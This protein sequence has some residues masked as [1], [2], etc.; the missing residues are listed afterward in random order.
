MK[1][2]ILI[3]A[4]LFV[5]SGSVNAGQ[6]KTKAQQVLQRYLD[7]PATQ[8][9]RYGDE[10]EKRLAILGE[11]KQTPEESVD[12][13]S[14]LLPTIEKSEQRAELAEY[15]GKNFQT[16][17]S[18]DI[19]CK[20]LKDTD[21]EVR[22][23][24]IGAIRLLSRRIDRT[25]A[26]RIQRISDNRSGAD[27]ER[28]IRDT[29]QPGA[30]V[31][32]VLTILPQDESLNEFAEFEP[33]VTGLVPYLV[34]AANDSVE[35]NKIAAMYALADSREPAAVTELHKLLRDPNENI[36][37]YAACFLT[38]FQDASGLFVMKAALKRLSES[39][40]KDLEFEYYAKSE[41]L[42]SSFERITGK[43]MGEIPMNPS[44]SS[45]TRQFEPLKKAHKDLLQSW[46]QWWAWEPN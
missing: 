3:T 9:N 33:K 24:A 12:A 29:I 2:S 41:M 27:K 30:V 8:E 15:L 25:G 23:Y 13:I 16:K 45:D 44:L 4:C 22:R 14:K 26:T 6:Q 10:R 1:I 32:R 19:L 20:L 39:E 35:T 31:T 18:A 46:S 38:E 17:A 21:S 7:V 43:S 11:L 28:A 5:M 36:Q 40:V 37:L 34:L 42:I